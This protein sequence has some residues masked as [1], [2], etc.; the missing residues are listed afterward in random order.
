MTPTQQIRQPIYPMLASA[1][2][3]VVERI[4]TLVWAGW[5]VA[6]VAASAIFAFKAH[7]IS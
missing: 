1:V 6:V 5:I 7:P 3:R 2:V 4:P